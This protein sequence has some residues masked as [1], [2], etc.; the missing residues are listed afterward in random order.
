ML[1]GGYPECMHCSVFKDHSDPV[2]VIPVTGLV[3]L[4]GDG[5][6]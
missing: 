2:G 4:E 1:P 5:A 6:V 3:R